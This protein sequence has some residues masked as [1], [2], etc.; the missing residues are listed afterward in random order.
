MTLSSKANAKK[1]LILQFS[2]CNLHNAT[3]MRID[4]DI[5]KTISRLYCDKIKLSEI[6]TNVMRHS[7]EC[8][9]IVMR[10]THSCETLM[11]MSHDCRVMHTLMSHNCRETLLRMSHDCCTSVVNINA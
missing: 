2:F 3:N 11:R 4:C 8:L 1:M 9:T 7:R 6:R 5:N 10:R